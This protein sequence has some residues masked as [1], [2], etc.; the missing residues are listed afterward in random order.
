VCGAF[1]CNFIIIT[2][3]LSFQAL[4]KWVGA[5]RTRDSY[6]GDGGHPEG[7]IDA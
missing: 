1:E 2:L 4:L 5:A 7:A 3:L 6:S